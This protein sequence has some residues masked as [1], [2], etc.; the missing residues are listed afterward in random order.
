MLHLGTQPPL[1]QL[2]AG[3]RSTMKDKNTPHAWLRSPQ[4]QAA[5]NNNKQDRTAP[6]MEPQVLLSSHVLIWI[7]PSKA[8]TVQH[9]RRC[10]DLEACQNRRMDTSSRSTCLH[11][12]H[13]TLQQLQHGSLVRHTAAQH[14]QQ[15]SRLC[16]LRRLDLYR[17]RR[18]LLPPTART[19]KAHHKLNWS[20]G[21]LKR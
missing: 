18:H 17:L 15:T 14:G 5:D 4:P 1:M 12:M 6:C 9:N 3:L 19:N 21:Q 10:Q 16:C 2:S 7:L 13:S 20:C 8:R 11:R